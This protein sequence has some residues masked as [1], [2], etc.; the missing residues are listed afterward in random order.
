MS[1][2]RQGET[3]H[4]PKYFDFDCTYFIPNLNLFVALNLSIPIHA[5][6][7]NTTTKSIT[8]FANS[9]QQIWTANIN[10]VSSARTRTTSHPLKYFDVDCTYLLS[11]LCLFPSL[12][13]VIPL[14]AKSNHT[15]NPIISLANSLQN[16]WTAN[17]KKLI[18]TECLP[19]KWSVPELFEHLNRSIQ[20][21]LP[22]AYEIKLSGRVDK[23][24]E[25]AFII[26]PA[27]REDCPDE[28][29]GVVLEVVD[30]ASDIH[31]KWK[32]DL[33]CNFPESCK[34][35]VHHLTLIQSL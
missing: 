26:D 29:K 6:C 8:S 4:L 5:D 2:A 19:I 20:E 33:T 1:S 11:N 34:C 22:H 14:H 18:Q 25:R 16:N 7:N 17:I 9:L 23:L 3:S 31:K 32:H 28:F 30:F 13:L 10:K 12:L 15:T 21:Y 24:A 27:A 35:E